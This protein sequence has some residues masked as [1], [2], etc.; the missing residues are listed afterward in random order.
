MFLTHYTYQYTEL[1]KNELLGHPDENTLEVKT[2][3]SYEKLDAR[4]IVK[5]GSIVKKG[6]VIVSKKQK[7]NR[8][9]EEGT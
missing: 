3:A 6:D 7:V 9:N 5:K 2:N 4:G 8:Q 1:E